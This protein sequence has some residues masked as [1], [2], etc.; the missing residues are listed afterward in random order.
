[1]ARYADSSDSHLIFIFRPLEANFEFMSEF[2]HTLKRKG[3]IKKCSLLL[4]PKRTALTTFFLKKFGLDSYLTP[5]S[6]YDLNFGLIP[7][8]NDL[9]SLEDSTV[10]PGM[11][12]KTG[13][14]YFNDCAISIQ[15]L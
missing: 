12:N 11:I 3:I 4:H 8:S 10:L 5:S 6:I 13:F 2:M 15:K 1:M 7:L 9:L 14:D